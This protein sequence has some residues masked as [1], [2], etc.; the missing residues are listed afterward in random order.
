MAAVVRVK[1]R[2]DQDP[3][4]SLLLSCKRFKSNEV[5]E[6]E[7]D[8]GEVKS[9]FKFAGTLTSKV[10]FPLNIHL[11]SLTMARAQPT[12]KGQVKRE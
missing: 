10:T 12:A 8:P 5:V 3:V 4:N 2:L 9:I 1:R 11:L 6:K 7:N